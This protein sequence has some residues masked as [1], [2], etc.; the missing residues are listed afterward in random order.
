MSANPY[1]PVTMEQSISTISPEVL[2]KI[3]L[4]SSCEIDVADAIGRDEND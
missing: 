4:K 2:E 3:T 1:L